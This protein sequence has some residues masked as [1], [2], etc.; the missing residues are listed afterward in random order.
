L[1]SFSRPFA[2]SNKF[3]FSIF[4]SPRILGKFREEFARNDFVL[5]AQRRRKN[6][7][8]P[9]GTGKSDNRE[10]STVYISSQESVKIN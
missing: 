2:N 9:F 4:P 7:L 6:K 3:L 5:A 1:G 10:I 8:G